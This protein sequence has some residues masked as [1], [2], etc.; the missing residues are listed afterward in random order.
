MLIWVLYDVKSNK[1]RNKVSST[2]KN[3]GMFP[4]QK[5]V[6]LGIVDSDR[7]E[8]FLDILKKNVGKEDSLI[9]LET[10]KKNVKN[11]V[12]IGKDIDYDLALRERNLMFF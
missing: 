10:S 2:C 11:S 3:F 12:V 7:L 4:I 9:I 8:T 1:T 6:F 5:S